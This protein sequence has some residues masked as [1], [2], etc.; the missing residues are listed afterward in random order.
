MDGAFTTLPI[1]F[2]SMPYAVATCMTAGDY[3]GFMIKP[4]SIRM[5]VYSEPYFGDYKQLFQTIDSFDLDLA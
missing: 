2:A 1:I 5:A 3:A 4:K